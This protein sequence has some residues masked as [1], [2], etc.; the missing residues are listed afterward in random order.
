LAS[1]NDG[2]FASP[3]EFCSEDFEGYSL[4]TS[5]A[6]SKSKGRGTPQFSTGV[7]STSAGNYASDDFE[8]ESPGSI[9]SLHN[10]VRSGDTLFKNGKFNS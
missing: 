3:E 1:L 6:L 7:T 10:S 8:L 4:G 5:P 2:R 9:S